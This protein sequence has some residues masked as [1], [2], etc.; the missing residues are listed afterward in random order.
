MAISKYQD[1]KPWN[2][3]SS[4]QRRQQTAV[5]EPLN[6][7]PVFFRSALFRD[8]STCTTCMQTLSLL[9]V[10]SC[11]TRRGSNLTLQELLLHNPPS[12]REVC[13]NIFYLDSASLKLANPRSRNSQEFG[14]FQL[15]HFPQA[16]KRT[17]SKSR[18]VH[19]RLLLT[20]HTHGWSYSR[21]RL[22]KP[23]LTNQQNRNAQLL[24]KGTANTSY[25]HAK[26][27]SLYCRAWIGIYCV[28]NFV[29][30]VVAGADSITLP[31]YYA[32]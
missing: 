18:G 1:P 16:M 28:Q 4:P 9:R 13:S 15:P 17:V 24:V 11:V 8:C 30:V 22:A 6:L 23:I 21:R 2:F 19:G 27:L 14:P 7:L 25:S 31:T 29:A 5:K 26:Y 12:H 10:G 20:V 3:M 32:D